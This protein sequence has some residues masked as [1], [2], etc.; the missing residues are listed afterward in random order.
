MGFPCYVCGCCGCD[1]GATG[2]PWQGKTAGLRLGGVGRGGHI[3]VQAQFRRIGANTLPTM[4]RLFL[5]LAATLALAGPAPFEGVAAAKDHGPRGERAERGGPPGWAGRPE[6]RG[7][8]GPD[9]RP[10]ENRGE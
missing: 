2:P 7:Y 5:T 3:G 9:G 10:G 6:R 1:R 8:E 4:K